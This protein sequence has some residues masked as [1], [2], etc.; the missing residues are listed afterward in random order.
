MLERI[1]K[2]AYHLDLAASKRQVLCGLHDIFHVNLLRH[3]QINELDY[4]AL[5]L[6]IY[7]EE[8]YE[9]QAI[10]KHC[11][12]CGEAQYLVK[13]TGYNELENLWLT[14]T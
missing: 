8:H 3:Y 5:P 10:R 4:K 14:A 12:V 6:E 7:G 9:V 11:V 13:R 2:T 1:G